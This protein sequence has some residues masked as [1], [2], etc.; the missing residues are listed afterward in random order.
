MKLLVA[1]YQMTYPIFSGASKN[2]SRYATPLRSRCN[3]AVSTAPYIPSNTNNQKKYK[4]NESAHVNVGNRLDLLEER[5]PISLSP[6][7]TSPQMNH[8]D[9]EN[10]LKQVNRSLHM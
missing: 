2:V 6:T 8:A 3:S 9:I 10:I 7:S 5:S 1:I 4:V